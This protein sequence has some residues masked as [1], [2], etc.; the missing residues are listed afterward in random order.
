MEFSQHETA[1]ENITYRTSRARS[2]GSDLLHD[3][4]GA[5]TR[6]NDHDPYD[7]VDRDAD[8]DHH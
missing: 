7:R 3:R 2:P 4:G 6:N 1:Y 8:A 5:G